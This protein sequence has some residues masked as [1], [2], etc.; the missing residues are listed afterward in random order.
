MPVAH[1]PLGYRE[2]GDDGSFEIALGCDTDFYA[3]RCMVSRS[4]L[5]F[6]GAQFVKLSA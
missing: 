3:A 2:N 1:G 6:G 4:A 5:F